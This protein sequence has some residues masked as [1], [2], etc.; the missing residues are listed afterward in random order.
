MKQAVLALTLCGNVFGFLAC[1]LLAGGR[2]QVVGAAMQTRSG[3]VAGE[4]GGLLLF[5][6]SPG[7]A[8]LA[9]V[10]AMLLDMFDGP[11][12]RKSGV[13]SKAGGWL[14][15]LTDVCIYVLFPVIFWYQ[16]YNLPAVILAVFMGAGIFRLVRFTLQGF[17]TDNA[18]LFYPGMPVFYSQFLLILTYALRFDALVLSAILVGVAALNV[19]VIP[20]AKIP[21]RLLS[22]GLVIY[23]AIVAMRLTNVL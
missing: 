17:Q 4:P 7:L 13:S 1:V 12:A 16:T 2:P 6:G 20:F 10:V 23:V 9:V 14:D 22:A 11:L 15:A 5:A 8:F 18:K 19:S 3:G 21:V